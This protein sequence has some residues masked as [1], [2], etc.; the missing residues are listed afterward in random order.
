MASTVIDGAGARLIEYSCGADPHVP[1]IPFAVFP[2]AL[3]SERSTS[4]VVDLDLSSC[5]LAGSACTSP[6]LLAAFVR[7]LPGERVETRRA[8]TSHAFF[9]IRGSGESTI[10]ERG[11][12][13]AWGAGD[14]FTVPACS[15]V[16][17]AASA[18][19]AREAASD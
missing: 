11:E 14:L 1:S 16:L 2:H 4:G 12:R 5:L 8:A 13:V 15:S 7:I 6:N 17:H 19:A 9:V 10:D 18:D 3:W